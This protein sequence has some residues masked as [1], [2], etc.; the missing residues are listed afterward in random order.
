M[1][2][3]TTHLED[4]INQQPNDEGCVKAVE[5]RGTK[6]D[7]EGGFGSVF[8][9]RRPYLAAVIAFPDDFVLS[10]MGAW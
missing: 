5:T 9:I 6:S 2:R 3:P 7:G 10:I 4:D 1:I 8:G